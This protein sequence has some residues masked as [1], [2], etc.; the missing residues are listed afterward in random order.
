MTTPEQEDD[1]MMHDMLREALTAPASV[2]ESRKESR[3]TE[4]L[5]E[6]SRRSD[7]PRSSLG[8]LTVQD[9]FSDEPHII[10][11]VN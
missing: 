9:E 8:E 7:F 1:Q 3:L 11:G 6:Q 4:Y 2:Q 10:R 5:K